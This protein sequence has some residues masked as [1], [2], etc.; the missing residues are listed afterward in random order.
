MKLLAK[1]AVIIHMDPCR[2]AQPR[3]ELRKSQQTELNESRSSQMTDHL[4]R[5]FY[6]QKTL[7]LC[8][9]HESVM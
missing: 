2:K 6:V 1:R 4:I 9:K 7:W 8:S 5:C 3:W